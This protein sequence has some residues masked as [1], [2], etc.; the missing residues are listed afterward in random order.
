MARALAG[1]YARGTPAASAT[2]LYVPGYVLLG[3][4]LDADAPIIT[5]GSGATAGQQHA[6]ELDYDLDANTFTVTPLPVGPYYGFE[7]DGNHRYCLA[8]FT[9]TRNTGKDA[10][11][12]WAILWFLVCFPY[13]KVPCTAP[14][15]HQLKDVLWSEIAKWLKGTDPAV[16]TLVSDVLTWQTDKIFHNAANGE[17]WFAVARTCNPKATVEEQAET[18]SGLHE[19]YMLI[20]CDEDSAIPEP[21]HRPLEGTLTGKVNLILLISNPTRTGGYFFK[22]Q[23]EDRYRLVA[24]HWNAEESEIVSRSSIEDQQKRYGAD[25]NAYRINVLGHFP[26]ISNDTLIAWEWA[27]DAIGRETEP[28]E[29][30]PEVFGIDVG[31]GGDPSVICHRRGP[32]VLAMYEKDTTEAEALVGWIMG[33][34]FAHEPQLVMIDPIGVGWGIASMLRTRLPALRLID[35]NVAE[36]ASEDHRFFRLRDELY[37]R[38]RELFESRIISIPDDPILLGEATSI[39]FE[40]PNGVIKIESKK[41][42]RRR[43]VKSP[44]RFDALTLTEYYQMET[45]RKVSATRL[46]SKRRLT[47]AAGWRVA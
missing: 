22:S 10:F 19:E 42:M 9:V 41:D 32:K 15:G 43:G 25:S 26:R 6:A 7:L 8:D 4:P 33:K 46:T 30:D 16:Q 20:V 5:L 23:H 29:A 11:A 31:A 35:V 17:R 28:M 34:I 14:T 18:L 44:N 2:G 24:L 3:D 40:E 12:S 37:W 39:K 1:D 47:G 13:S 21:V 38:V 27:Q 36:V 45:M